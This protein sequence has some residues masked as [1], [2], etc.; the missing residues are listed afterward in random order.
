MPWVLDCLPALRIEAQTV[1]PGQRHVYGGDTGLLQY[2]SGLLDLAM[3]EGHAQKSLSN[4][5]E[6]SNF[7]PLWLLPLAVGAVSLLGT[8]RGARAEWL[9]ARGLKIA[10][11]FYILAVTLYMFVA[12]PPWLANAFLADRSY[13]RRSL[14][15][16]GVAGTL[17]LMLCLATRRPLAWRPGRPA[18]LALL[19]WMLLVAGVM[20]KAQWEDPAFLT[21]VSGA[22]LLGVALVLGAAYV[23]GPRWLLPA[24]WAAV[25]VSQTAL[26]NPVCDG[27]PSLLESPMLL[28]VGAIVRADPDAQWALYNGAVSSELFKTAG[29]Q[30]IDGVRI[31]PDPEL[32]H[33]LD[34]A[35]AHADIF[36]RYSHLCFGFA[37]YDQGIV[38][39]M[40]N[41]VYVQVSLHP[42]RL[43]EIFPK[44]RYL[45]SARALPEAEEAGFRL[46]W[47]YDVNRLWLYAIQ[48]PEDAAAAPAQRVDSMRKDT[49]GA[50]SFALNGEGAIGRGLFTNAR[51]GEVAAARDLHL[52]RWR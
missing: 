23:A 38:V 42:Q 7:F 12:L 18:L 19:G 15:G 32:I 44:L 11:A 52:G 45:V 26:V 4:V 9:R 29:A 51:Q 1:Y 17:L 30:L 49:V 50:E 2:F 24:A 39:T 20:A 3:T 21:W 14:L 47:R 41:L 13:G 40:L 28:K 48:P 36:N 8:Q 37:Q 31:I 5:C 6:A 10:L 43:R 27:L 33:K 16:L 22:A 35:G 46:V 34:P 25:F